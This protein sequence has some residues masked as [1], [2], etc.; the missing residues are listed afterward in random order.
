MIW[1]II[2]KD[3]EKKLGSREFN[4]YIK[5]IKFNEEKSDSNLKVLEVDNI[6]ILTSFSNPSQDAPL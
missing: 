1:N 6:F 5:N 4:R 3:L 2:L